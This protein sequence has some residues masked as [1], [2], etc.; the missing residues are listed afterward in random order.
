MYKLLKMP[1]TPEYQ[2][3]NLPEAR[4]VCSRPFEN[5]DVDFCDPFWIKEK[6]SFAIA[7]KLRFT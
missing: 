3:D 1:S 6:K 5:I 4:L 2:M 7:I